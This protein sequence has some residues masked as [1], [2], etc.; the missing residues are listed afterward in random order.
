MTTRQ[1]QYECELVRMGDPREEGSDISEAVCRK[2]LTMT[3]RE[4]HELLTEAFGEQEV[5]QLESMLEMLRCTDGDDAELGRLL[6][7]CLSEY[8]RQTI[9]GDYI[10]ENRLEFQ[11]TESKAEAT[12]DDRYNE[13]VTQ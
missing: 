1:Y 7:K 4:E 9:I 3:K 2:L 8:M 11:R 6:R 12:A 5:L 10:I 13:S